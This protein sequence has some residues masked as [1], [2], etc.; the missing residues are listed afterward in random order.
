MD[1]VPKYKATA[2]KIFNLSE[3]IGSKVIEKL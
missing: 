1:L 2:R 3:F